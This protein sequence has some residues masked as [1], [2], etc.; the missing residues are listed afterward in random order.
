MLKSNKWIYFA[1]S[2]PF[3][4]V[5]LP[6]IIN[7]DFSNSNLIYSKDAKF[8]L[9]NEDSIKNEII[10]ELETEK[11]YVKSVTLLPNTARGEYDN[12]GDVSGNYHVYFSAY[13]NGNQN[14]SLK[15]ELY[16]PDAG[17]PPFTF[18]HPDPYKDKEEKMSRWS[19]DILEVSDDP[20]WNREQDQD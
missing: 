17:I 13:A 3:L 16:F 9:E 7:G 19:I 2:L 14:Q 6:F 1:I 5:C 12:G 15:V 20:S 18:I 8:I 10:T 11:Q 4:I